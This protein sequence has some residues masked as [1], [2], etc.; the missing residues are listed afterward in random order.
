MT[1]GHSYQGSWGGPT[2]QQSSYGNYGG[3][4]TNGQQAPNTGYSPVSFDDSSSFGES[5]EAFYGLYVA[6]EI[7]YR[8]I[9]LILRYHRL[10]DRSTNRPSDVL[11]RLVDALF[12]YLDS[13]CDVPG[14]KGTQHIEPAKFG[15]LHKTLGATPDDVRRLLVQ[16]L[17]LTHIFLNL[18]IDKAEM[19]SGD[20]WAKASIPHRIV[21]VNGQ[22]TPILDRRGF[23]HLAVF[24]I[25]ASPSETHQVRPLC[26]LFN[27]LHPNGS[28]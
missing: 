13:N 25:R 7:L 3:G 14:L 16:T 23:L 24:A 20:L 6:L 27:L 22:M 1:Y 17:R 26:P 12:F 18:Q 28:P 15:W 5:P 8:Q 9:G 21:N 2:N 11:C 19:A 4:S 10:I